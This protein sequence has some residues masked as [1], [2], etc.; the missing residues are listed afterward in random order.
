MENYI[1][2]SRKAP[3][4]GLALFL[5]AYL[6]L[7]PNV[8][9]LP[10]WEPYDTQ[11]LLQVLI[12]VGTAGWLLLSRVARAAWL[13][14]FTS[15][16]RAA[17]WGLG[18]IMA[19]GVL[20]A[21][22][23][24]HPRYGLLEVGHLT[25]VVVLAVSVAAFVRA[26]P[27]A[28]SLYWIGTLLL[29]AGLY[30]LGF[31]VV[32]ADNLITHEGR[33]WPQVSHIGFSHVRFFN[34]VQTWT[35]PLVVVPLV[36]LGRG[37]WVKG[38]MGEGVRWAFIGLMLL[39]AAGWWML[40]LASGG[41]GTA[42]AMAGAL[43]LA[44]VL[45]RRAAL[46]WLGAM[47]GSLVIG[48]GCYF[49]FFQWLPGSESLAVDL[50]GTEAGL[51]TRDLSASMSR[52]L[53]WRDAWALVQAHPLL[54]AGPMHYAV[55]GMAAAHPHSAPV[56]WA[57][58]WGLPSVLAVV[59]LV[60]WG[61]VAW[62]RQ[63]LRVMQQGASAL[64]VVR[65]GLTAALAAGAAHALVSGIIVMPVSQMLLAVVIGW[66]WGLFESGSVGEGENGRTGERARESKGARGTWRTGVLVVVLVA[67]VG[68][69]VWGV[70]PDVTRLDERQATYL[71][72]TGASW[73]LPRYWQQGYI[74]W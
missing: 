59:G 26:A 71:K 35:L 50:P 25:L 12:L 72:E 67:A 19:L 41:R 2:S 14:V 38:R 27:Q 34:Q 30:L 45:Y 8:N 43:V 61:F 48:I 49:L 10:D 65:V 3:G 31:A 40:L 5:S 15:L 11:R 18:G 74:D 42:I 52:P 44:G 17:Q 46:P 21:V 73:L 64:G 7:V 68:M 23:A 22:L 57:A 39:V 53:Y 6:V 54:G 16:P 36:W 66:A 55:P 62:V 33:L 32:H 60:G 58:E 56:Q 20:S 70:G 1:T 9:V 13:G 51:L 28:A 69:V 47:G 37:E 24:P 63:S 29:L 4:F